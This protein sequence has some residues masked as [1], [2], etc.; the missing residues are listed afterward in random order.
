LFVIYEYIYLKDEH[1]SVSAGMIVQKTA[2]QATFDIN[3]LENVQK[4]K[5]LY[6]Q[7]EKLDYDV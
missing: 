1:Q 7:E 3:T 6:L 2:A 4:F 5:C